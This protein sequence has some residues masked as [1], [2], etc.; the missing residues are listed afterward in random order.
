MRRITYRHILIKKSSIYG[1][2]TNNKYFIKELVKNI[3][4]YQMI[5]DKIYN[6]NLDQNLN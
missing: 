6:M 5:Y 1:Y 2:M 4:G 3:A